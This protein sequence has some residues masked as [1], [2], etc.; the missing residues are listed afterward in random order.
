[1]QGD[2]MKKE[3]QSGPFF[4]G[5]IGLTS[6]LRLRAVVSPSECHLKETVKK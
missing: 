5:F 2:E 4:I 6:T 3:P 1:M